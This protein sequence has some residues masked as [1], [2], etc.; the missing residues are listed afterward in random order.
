MALRRVSSRAT[1]SAWAI[2]FPLP[3]LINVI[4]GAEQFIAIFLD[5]RGS[6]RRGMG[7]KSDWPR[8]RF[9]AITAIRSRSRLV[10]NDR[11]VKN[12]R[13]CLRSPRLERGRLVTE[14]M[15]PTGGT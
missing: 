7:P 14:P 2:R 8:P 10:V 1:Q 13:G 15:M 12:G 9:R 11:A 3:W 4:G 6:L 5:A